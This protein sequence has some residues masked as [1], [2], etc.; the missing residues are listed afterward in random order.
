MKILVVGSVALDDVETPFGAVEGV[1][2][3]AATYFATVASLYAPINL[4]AVVG[5]DF[6]TD[7][8]RF[9]QERG[10]D[11]SG[12][13]IVPDGSTFHWAGRYDYDF[14][15]CQTLQTDLNV[16]A[17]FH[18]VLP[19]AY[20]DSELVFLANIDPVL[21]E[22]VLR[23]APHARLRVV[24]TMNYWISDHRQALARTLSLADVALMNEA[25]VRQ[26]G[27]TS[28]L[29]TA[30]RAILDLGPRAVIVKRGEYGAMMI[31]RNDCFSVPAYPLEEVRDPTG[32]GDSFAGGLLGYMAASGDVS[33][34][35]LRR[36]IVHGCITGSF[37]VEDF[38]IRR[39]AGLR[40]DEIAERYNDFVRMTHFHD[41]AASAFPTLPVS[42]GGFGC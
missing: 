16:F 11:T 42:S 40:R 32:A 36:G 27:G 30:A 26:F 34:D 37:A 10:V 14:N 41:D 18:P 1:V 39:L 13:Q 31:T 19:E 2:G 8:V 17:D 21:Q 23:Q 6:P 20:R 38:S 33:L 9:L 28:K 24:D 4:V 3:G 35:S 29:L 25:E 15:N 12:L 22:E 5:H 7:T